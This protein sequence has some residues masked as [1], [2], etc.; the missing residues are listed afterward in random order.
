MF[1]PRWL[2][3]RYREEQEIIS[4]FFMEHGDVFDTLTLM[5]AESDTPINRYYDGNI[6][7]KIEKVLDKEVVGF[8]KRY[9][10]VEKLELGRDRELVLLRLRLD[11]KY[12]LLLTLMVDPTMRK[13]F[14]KLIGSEEEVFYNIS[15]LGKNDEVLLDYTFMVETPL[16]PL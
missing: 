8:F 14:K 2:E 12:I 16:Q 10:R 1:E 7:K 4:L 6:R 13:S 11:D 15:L 5:F 9:Y 3:L